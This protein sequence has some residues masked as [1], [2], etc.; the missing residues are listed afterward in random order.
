MA[1]E[2]IGPVEYN[3]A[4]EHGRILG[5]YDVVRAILGSFPAEQQKLILADIARR[6]QEPVQQV[7][8]LDD[9][10][11]N[12]NAIVRLGR[13]VS[14]EDLVGVSVPIEKS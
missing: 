13:Q 5:L 6:V 11:A 7:G 8:R 9:L 14:V 1:E 10:P 4:F 3:S 12:H 2:H